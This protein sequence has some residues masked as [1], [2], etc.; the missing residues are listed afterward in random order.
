MKIYEANGNRFILGSEEIDVVK[1]CEEYRCDGYLKMFS[2]RMSIFNAD[3]SEAL[4]CVN[5]LHCFAHYLY[6]ENEK[7]DVF[8]LVV[9]NEIYKCEIIQKEPFISVVT[10]K[11]PVIYRNFVDVGNEHMILLDENMENAAQLCKRFDCNISYVRIISQSC[12]E[13]KTYERGVGFTLSCGSGNIASSYY[14]YV[15]GLCDAQVNILNEGGI[16]FIEIKDH[17]EMKAM[18]RFVQE[19]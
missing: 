10:V 18:S 14:C 9:Q 7:Y 17:V 1:M 13:V 4:L 19:I 11:I 5:G 8:A 2:H 3:G 15:N 16:C 12:I 6:D